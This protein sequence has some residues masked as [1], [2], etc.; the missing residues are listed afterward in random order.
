[1]VY[2]SDESLGTQQAVAR[3]QGLT[4]A[5]SAERVWRSSDGITR[6]LYDDPNGGSWRIDADCSGADSGDSR[7]AG[8]APQV[9]ALMAESFTLDERV[10]ASVRPG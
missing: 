5:D 10:T 8:M 4:L 7:Y 2:R 9:L 3:E 6:Y 1:M